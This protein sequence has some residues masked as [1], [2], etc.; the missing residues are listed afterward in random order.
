MDD[1]PARR[2]STCTRR[3]RTTYCL[4]YGPKTKDCYLPPGEIGPA[5]L[6]PDGTVFDTG[7]GSGPQRFRRRPHGDLSHVGSKA[8]HVDSRTGL[9]QRRQRRRL[10]RRACFR[11]ETCSCSASAARSTSSTVRSSPR[12][13]YLE[14]SA[15]AAADRT[16]ADAR[17]QQLELYTPTGNPQAVVGA[18]DQSVADAAHARPHVQDLR[19]AV[20]RA[21]ASGV[22]RRRV[23][24]RDELP[25]RAHHQQRDRA[26]VLRPHA[27]PQHDGRRHRLA[28]VS[29][30]FDVPTTDRNR[31][32]HARQVVANGI[33]ST[34]VNVTVK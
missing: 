8:G 28:R 7:S 18:D 31:R 15:A 11:A 14:R 34:P 26:H 29:T 4:Q 6:R 32:E 24:E 23:P 2:S 17:L 33:A 25:A 21:L 3:R 22:V 27:R 13:G 19:H 12:S 1:A 9:P 30:N 20:Q 10:V 16:G 5:I